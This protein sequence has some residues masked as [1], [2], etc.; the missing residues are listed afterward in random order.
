MRVH[1]CVHVC[2][3]VGVGVSE[4]G[5]SMCVCPL[6]CPIVVVGEGGANDT[7][8]RHGT[9]IRVMCV[10][11]RSYCDGCGGCGASGDTDT[12]HNSRSEWSWSSMQYVADMIATVSWIG[13]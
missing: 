11:E 3:W 10:G 4:G 9:I 8:Q 12:R 1:A 6:V 5:V 2:V 13:L 7:F